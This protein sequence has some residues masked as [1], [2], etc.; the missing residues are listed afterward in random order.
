VHRSQFIRGALSLSVG[1]VL[2][3]GSLPGSAVLG[4]G[5]ALGAAPCPNAA[6]RAD[7]PDAQHLPDCRAYEQVSPTAKNDADAVGNMGF[8]ESA[9]SGEATSFFSVVPF[10]S[11]PG[12]SEVSGAAEFLDYVARRT[13]GGGWRTEGL[14]PPSA[15]G[16]EPFVTGWTEDLGRTLVIARD[17]L[18]AAGAIPGVFNA[19]LRNNGA[20][21]YEFLSGPDETAFFVASTPD[22]SRI[23][24][25]DHGDILPGVVDANEAPMLYL[26]DTTRPQGERV[27]LVGEVEGG[28]P[29]A[30]TVPGAGSAQRGY[31]EQGTLSADGSRAFFTDRD[32][33]RIYERELDAHVT[34]S[35]SVGE[36]TWLAATPDGSRVFYTEH[37][38]LFA[39]DTA[40]N[41][42]S[43][44]TSPGAEVEGT[45]GVSDDGSYVY[46]V[47]R[48]AL[49]PEAV[50]G[51]DNLYEWHQGKTSLVATVGPTTSGEDRETDWQGAANF[52]DVKFKASRVTPEGT[53]LLFS[54]R[55]SLTGYHAN[56]QPELYLFDGEQPRGPGNPLCVSCNPTGIP[57]SS[58]VRLNGN[59]NTGALPVFAFGVL[60]RYLSADGNKVFFE[61]SEALVPEDA[62]GQ[63]DVYEWERTG[64]G[65][66]VTIQPGCLSLIS[67]GHSTAESYFGDA[68]ATGDNVFFFTREP[69]V[70]EDRDENIDVYDAR[71]NGGIEAR[72]A[73][74]SVSSCEGEACR[75][76]SSPP[77]E[78]G[79]PASETLAGS[80]ELAAPKTVK[81]V[82]KHVAKPKK[83]KKKHKPKHNRS[84]PRAKTK[85]STKGGR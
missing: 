47:A 15:P 67:T 19:Y 72:E 20:E 8:V 24:F 36:A 7:Q 37:E 26:Y 84:K 44:V 69:L 23:L 11:V 62:N 41:E 10:P 43:A 30:G 78:G 70:G 3:G 12:R 51:G 58:G 48:A 18:L 34:R 81:A 46:F 52:E 38:Q 60:P 63:M 75:G 27:E 59:R 45:A 85:Q 80:G 74:P 50:P 82:K 54:S 4:A 9:P 76:L 39:F 22:D 79:P 32:N 66:C 42:R 64:T 28:A 2:L 21:T 53:K 25:E 68:S 17:P 40:E 5:S 61:T 6:L 16:V 31:Y 77:A 33:G 1:L 13:D 29:E 71:V 83:K 56:E 35:V 73:A 55:A 65:S 14:L 49:A 57:A